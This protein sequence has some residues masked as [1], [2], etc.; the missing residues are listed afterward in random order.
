M[1]EFKPGDYVIYRKGDE[2]Q[3]GKV[4]RVTEDGAFVWYSSGDTASRTRA[5]NLFP[6]S[7]AYVIKETL[8]PNA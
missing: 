2:F 1:K 4:K 7:N 8:F 6:I 5:E 3:I